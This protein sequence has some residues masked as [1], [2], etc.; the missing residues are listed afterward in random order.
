[1]AAVGAGHLTAF[2]HPGIERSQAGLGPGETAAAQQQG[3]TQY[4][5]S[6]CL[7]ASSAPQSQRGW[8]NASCSNGERAWLAFGT[9][10]G[11]TNLRRNIRPRDATVPLSEPS[12]G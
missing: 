7:P 12:F 8:N 4:R 10:S 5:A 2:A 6:H 9:L 1:M 3:H 11:G